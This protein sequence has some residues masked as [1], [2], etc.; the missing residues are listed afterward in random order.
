[1][2]KLTTLFAICL[3]VFAYGCKKDN[4][5]G[6][7]NNTIDTK[8][9]FELKVGDDTFSGNEVTFA[10]ALGLQTIS[11][12]QNKFQFNLLVPAEKFTEGKV[13][14]LDGEEIQPLITCDFDDDGEQEGY[15]GMEGKLKVISKHKIEIDGVFYRDFVT[16][17]PGKVVK[18]YIS[19]K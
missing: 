9:S 6:T 2:K 7:D 17:V 1:M 8:G 16:I 19:S 10:N 18:G 12:E 3:L 5:N 15:W 14:V 11:I 4:D 13:F